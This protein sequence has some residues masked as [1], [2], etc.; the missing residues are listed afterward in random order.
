MKIKEIWLKIK[1]QYLPRFC[2][3]EDYRAYLQGKGVTVGEGT[4]F[5]DWKSNFIDTERAWMLSIGRFCKI[6]RGVIILNHDYSR[7]VLRRVYGEIVG[8]AKNTSI[9]DNVFLGMNTIVLMGSHIGNNVIIGAGSVVTGDI[10]DNVVAAGSPA[11]VVCTLEEYW[12]K[13][14]ANYSEDARACARAYYKRYNRVPSIKEMNAFFPLYL[15][16]NI[17]ILVKSGVKIN[18]SG[19]VESEVIEEFMKSQPIYS[20]Y[21]AFL[22]AALEDENE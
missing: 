17:E 2:K 10:P 22:S 4:T 21:E 7:S 1:L 9:G 18:L 15:E 20:S 5:F 8:E 16:R 19:D 3:Q 14:K 12:K 11:K 13:R 6:T